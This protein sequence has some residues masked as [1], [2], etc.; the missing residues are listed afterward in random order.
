MLPRKLQRKLDLSG[1][2][3]RQ[4]DQARTGD[5]TSVLVIK[6]VVVIWRF[7]VGSVE[8]IVRLRS[9]LQ[10][11]RLRDE[12]QR[13]A[14]IDGKIHIDD[15]WAN[16]FISPCIAQAIRTCSGDRS[17]R[18]GVRTKGCARDWRVCRRKGWGEAA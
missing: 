5:W 6:S 12:F 13:V 10:V 11:S 16:Q 17:W 8:H 4:V 14:L 2:N 7:E 3:R 1:G 18:A 9:K 15:P